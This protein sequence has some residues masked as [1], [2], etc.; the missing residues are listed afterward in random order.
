M[1][2]NYQDFQPGGS[3]NELPTIY[4]SDSVVVG[5]TV[6]TSN[7]IVSISISTITYPSGSFALPAGGQTITL[8]GNY[9]EEG[10]ALTVDGSAVAVTRIS[11]TS[12][13]FTSPAKSVGTYNVVLTNPAG[14]TASIS[15]VYAVALPGAP[16]IGTAT[17]TGTTSA[18]VAFTAPASDGGSVITTYTATSTPGGITGTLNQAGSGTITVNGLSQGTA[19]IFTVTATNSA[20]TG[21]ASGTSN[22]I[23]TFAT[24][25]NSDAP[26]VSGTANFGQTLSCTT[27]I[28]TGTATI[29]YAYQWQR[30]GSNISSAT[31]STYTLVQADVGN[32]I[33]CVV[34]GTNSYG[35][36]S[37][38]SNSTAA[39]SAIAP[40]APTIGTATTVTK[41][42]ATVTFTAPA[43][44]G[45]AT[46]T[47]YTA[48]SS[49]G[50]ITGT[51]SQSG[52]GTITVTGLTA[53]TNY[54]F[55]VTATNS[56]G[57]SSASGASNQITTTV[58]PGAPTI[59]TAT[60][61]SGTSAT[62]SFTAPADDGGGTI[63]Q[64]TATSSPGNVTGTL[65]QAGSG[66]ITVNGLTA[67]SSY[68]FT[69]TA[70][71]SAGTSAASAASNSITT[72]TVPG[73]PTIGTATATGGTTATVS[74]TAPASDG[75]ATITTYTAT[76]SPGS[77][78]GTLNQAGSGTITVTGL[79]ASTTYTF[80]V[81][82]T[83][84]AG[85][86]SASEASN[87]IT[88]LLSG[89][90]WSWGNNTNLF[91]AVGV[92][93]DQSN[94]I[95]NISNDNN[96]TQV[97]SGGRPTF[98]IKTD[99]T[100]WAWGG[101]N[102]GGLGDGSLIGRNS[103]VQN[104]AG[105]TTWSVAAAGSAGGVA[106]KT[107][108]TLWT[109]GQNNFGQLGNNNTTN[110]SSPDQT[111]A[112]GTTWSSVAMASSLSGAIK[113]DGTLWTW[114]RNLSGALGNNNSISQS[115]PVQ[116]IASGTNWKQIAVGG[117]YWMAS[118][119]TDG[120]LWSWGINGNGQ[121]GNNTT[122]DKSSPIQTVSA[123][124][125]WKQITA[126][127]RH[128]AAIK[129]DGTLWTW[130]RNNY[131]QLG[132]GTTIDRSSPVQ[133]VSGDTTWSVV[134]AGNTGMTASIKTDGTLWTWGRNNI[135]QLGDGTI[136]QRKLLVFQLTCILIIIRLALPI[137]H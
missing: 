45:G 50:N 10:M 129:T 66:T 74:F 36:S 85:T 56:A 82:A 108:G 18:T 75:G 99:G 76:S 55:T 11:T 30:N 27:G 8:T 68:T 132:D 122:S 101:N 5:G 102:Y 38:N 32:P 15:M 7:S 109:W 77:I 118:I 97:I 62:V 88:T 115:S 83:N 20:G 95:Q 89:N 57:T 3:S 131:A 60:T 23:T 44:N 119:K 112:G 17:V 39:V 40:D 25:V 91:L 6:I 2:T 87:A 14:T 29:T 136:I 127:Y 13:T 22:S 100:L 43:S 21:S 52:S 105:G 126:G 47:T 114:G 54:T 125:N 96:W 34:T 9:F 98:G 107:D 106:I 35:S 16:T 123:G 51:L 116:T 94:P 78:T 53:G 63:T 33:R 58:A 79:S 120:T 84:T 41:T 81:T 90:I 130:G 111:V 128:A 46:I 42:S 12:A 69:V 61:V 37:A 133:T 26:V 59:G 124:T 65:S 71:N 73:A 121:L 48:T 64:Y 117:F 93:G 67:G 72:V 110:T 80:T 1:T 137:T 24:P 113:T 103:P 70:T 28:W 92:S 135:G 86:S 19:Y 104:A 4:L 49:P 31:S 134:S